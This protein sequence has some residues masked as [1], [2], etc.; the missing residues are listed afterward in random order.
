MKKACSLLFLSTV[1]LG[2]IDAEA[3]PIRAAGVSASSYLVSASGEAYEV[4][5][6]ADGKQETAWIEGE[7]GSGLGSWVKI[8]LGASKRITGLQFWNG[9]WITA[10]FWSRHNRAKEVEVEL[11]DGGKHTFDLKDEMVPETVR[12]PAPVDTTSVNIRIKSVHRGSTFNDT[13]FAEIRVLDGAPPDFVRPS[14]YRSSSFLPTDGD[15]NYETKNLHDGLADS[16]WCEGNQEGDGKG[17][18]VEFDFG[19]ERQVSK[20]RIRNG[21]AG[22]FSAFM[23]TNR[24]KAATLE[25]S[26]GS[27]STVAIKPSL[28]EQVILFSGRQT[29]RVKVTFTDVVKGTKYNDLCVSEAVF[30]P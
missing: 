18:W 17:E 12:F 13:A 29:A 21:S 1:A 19:A 3:R 27:R 6:I 4:K 24:A 20:L 23:Q 16:M 30:L 25:F 14:T 7:D 22:S 26:D 11:S 10:D 9:Y 2:S 5:H 8:D 28:M 15:G